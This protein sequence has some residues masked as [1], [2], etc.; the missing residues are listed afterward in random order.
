MYTNEV[1]EQTVQKARKILRLKRKIKEQ[2]KQTTQPVRRE[3]YF[4][5][6]NYQFY[7]LTTFNVEVGCLG[8]LIQKAL[9]LAAI[10]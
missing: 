4:N 10:P 1:M 3:D 6:N 9:L 8:T 5:M 7:F 2:Q